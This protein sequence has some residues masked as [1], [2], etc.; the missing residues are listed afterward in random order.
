ME[1]HLRSKQLWLSRQSRIL[2]DQEHSQ[3][4]VDCPAMSVFEKMIR[5]KDLAP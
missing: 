4:P 1:L 3:L 5:D 2:N